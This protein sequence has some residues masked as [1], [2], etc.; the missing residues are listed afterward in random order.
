MARS[1][2]EPRQFARPPESFG[3]TANPDWH[4][5][6]G[7][8]HDEVET[9]QVAAVIQ[10]QAC[11]VLRGRLKELG[12][13][14]PEFARQSGVHADRLRRILRGEIVMQLADLARLNVVGLSVGFRVPP[15]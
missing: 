3:R 15:K 4:P 14:V 2:F 8:D 6:A 12:M 7:T 1:R 10:H 5:S 9:F 13:S 11:F